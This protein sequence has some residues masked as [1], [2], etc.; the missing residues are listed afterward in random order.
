MVELVW[1]SVPVCGA[2]FSQKLEISSALVFCQVMNFLQEREWGL[3]I[4]DGES[5]YCVTAAGPMC[6]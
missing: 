3:M 2:K 6:H 5:L 4:L 1:L